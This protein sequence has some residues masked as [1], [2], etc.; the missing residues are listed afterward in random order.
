MA[1]GTVWHTGTYFRLVGIEVYLPGAQ[2][3]FRPDFAVCCMA[4]CECSSRRGIGG[5]EVGGISCLTVAFG[6]YLAL[7]HKCCGKS[8]FLVLFDGVL[9]RSVW[10]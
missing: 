7:A 4:C 1:Y 8:P 5:R 10:H 2:E 6:L 9:R 3:S